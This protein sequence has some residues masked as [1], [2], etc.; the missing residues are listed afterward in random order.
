MF[1]KENKKG[2]CKNSLLHVIVILLVAI[3]M[4]LIF[5][6]G[7]FVGG[8]KS[9]SCSFK[10]KKNISWRNIVECKK[11]ILTQWETKAKAKGMT[12]EE[13]KKSLEKEKK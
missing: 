9:D 8:L 2:M 7:M 13:Y 5:K 1:G 11:N 4:I 10:A 3:L 6:A 12:L